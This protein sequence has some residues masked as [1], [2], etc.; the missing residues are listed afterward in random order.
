[1]VTHPGTLQH[2]AGGVRDPTADLSVSGRPALPPDS[3]SGKGRRKSSNLYTPNSSNILLF[4][5]SPALH[6][7]YCL[8]NLIVWK[9][10]AEAGLTESPPSKSN[11]QV[12]Y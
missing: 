1:M 4:E 8:L 3:R 9:H 6:Y 10:L 5:V 12:I 7:I 11:R 2:T